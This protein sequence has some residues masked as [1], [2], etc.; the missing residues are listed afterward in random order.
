MYILK[1]LSKDPRNLIHVKKR[2]TPKIIEDML[3]KLMYMYIDLH[4]PTFNLSSTLNLKQELVSMNSSL[5]QQKSKHD[6]LSKN[7]Q[8]SSDTGADFEFPNQSE[9]LHSK[10]LKRH[11]SLVG[12][13]IYPSI[14][15][16]HFFHKVNV[17]FTETGTIAS[18]ATVGLHGR[19]NAKSDFSD[20][21][22]RRKRFLV[23]SHNLSWTE[24]G[25][26]EV[27]I[28]QPF[29]F[30]IKHDPTNLILFWGTVYDPTSN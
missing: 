1:P 14:C 4:I 18:S 28:N 27:D 3:G 2:L 8:H 11:L 23:W 26:M 6:R 7:F 17:E 24:N 5:P 30:F 13:L 10:E 19:S 12:E 22:H 21:P 15:L 16:S 9:S 20:Y 29:L 25:I